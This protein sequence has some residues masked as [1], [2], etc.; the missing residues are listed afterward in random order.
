MSY[1]VS[2]A[3]QAAVYQQL[4][5]DV[6]LAGLVGTA[7]YDA[8]PNG[9]LPS[10][11]V[12]LGEDSTQDASDVTGGGAWHRLTVSVISDQAGFHTAKSVAAAISD[13][14]VDAD[15]TLTTGT[16]VA[17]HFFRAR[18]AREDTGDTRRIDIVFRARVD[19]S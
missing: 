12:L 16:L 6:T 2:A 17:L 14:L 3:L 10:T 5:G 4:A 9:T 19:A 7:I 18:A 11:Y 15:L 8:L 13:A 1:A